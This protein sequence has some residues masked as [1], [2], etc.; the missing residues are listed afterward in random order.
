MMGH[1]HEVRFR[2]HEG[3]ERTAA[4]EEGAT[5]VVYTGP[6]TFE[7][8]APGG[9]ATGT[10]VGAPLVLDSPEV[11]SHP[12]GI[13]CEVYELDAGVRTLAGTGSSFTLRDV[14]GALAWCV[15]GEG[16]EA[17]AAHIECVVD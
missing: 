15:T 17:C 8:I 11:P 16:S 2:V 6:A 13:E 1:L 10:F 9:S 4:P 5:G 14:G 12:H 7:G 3:D